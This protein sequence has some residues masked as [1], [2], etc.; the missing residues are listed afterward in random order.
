M[1]ITAG[2]E[3]GTLPSDRGKDRAAAMMPERRTERWRKPA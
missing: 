3:K 1:P 2:E